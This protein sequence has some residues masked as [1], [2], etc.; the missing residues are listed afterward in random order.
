MRFTL[1]DIGIYKFQ[2]KIAENNSPLINKDKSLS[3]NKPNKLKSCLKI[4]TN[5]TSMA[6]EETVI[7]SA[8]GKLN[9]ASKL[10]SP[11]FDLY[12]KDAKTIFIKNHDKLKRKMVLQTFKKPTQQFPVRLT[13]FDKG[14]KYTHQEEPN[15]DPF[16]TESNNIANEFS[17][18]K[19]GDR[20]E[21]FKNVLVTPGKQLNKQYTKTFKV[22]SHLS[23]DPT[24]IQL[25]TLLPEHMRAP[26][27]V[28][29]TNNLNMLL[30]SNKSAKRIRNKISTKSMSTQTKFSKTSV[31]KF[32]LKLDASKKN[33]TVKKFILPDVHNLF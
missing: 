11:K 17:A 2:N 5:N 1:S 19:I 23:P 8:E 33:F 26:S 10:K 21:L 32:E 20:I 14:K 25:G 13:I 16:K 9:S 28:N 31:N 6:D 7:N 15:Y 3:R 22:I 18:M 24:K 12:S 29:V 27:D 4:F 30:D